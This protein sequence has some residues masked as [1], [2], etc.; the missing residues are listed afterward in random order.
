MQVANNIAK[1][2]HGKRCV[3]DGAMDA[4]L[5]GAQQTVGGTSAVA[6]MFAAWKALTDTVAGAVLPFSAAS[7]YECVLTTCML[8][9]WRPARRAAS[10]Y[11][12]QMHVRQ[13][14]CAL[15]MSITCMA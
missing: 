10:R 1:L 7:V 6:P 15:E 8:A 9:H 4:D 2:G 5:N 12:C 13:L 11:C 3:P 14:R